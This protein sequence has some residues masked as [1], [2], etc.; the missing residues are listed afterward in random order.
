MIAGRFESSP[1]QIKE[2]NNLKT[3]KIYI[4]QILRIP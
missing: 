1:F 4:G 2:L 3:N